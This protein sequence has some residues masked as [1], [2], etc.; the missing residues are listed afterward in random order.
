MTALGNNGGLLW[1]SNGTHKNNFWANFYDLLDCQESESE[2]I[3]GRRSICQS[4]S[5]S[6]SLGIEPLPGLVISDT[7]PKWRWTGRAPGF[8]GRGQVWCRGD[9]TVMGSGERG[10]AEVAGTGGPGAVPLNNWW[11]DNTKNTLYLYYKDNS[12]NAVW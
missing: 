3:Y 9:V 8:W 10:P 7:A 1:Y 5:Q 4:V 6:V 11:T 12:V 2:S